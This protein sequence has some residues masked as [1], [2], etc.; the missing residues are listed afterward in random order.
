[1]ASA[2]LERSIESGSNGKTFTYSVWFKLSNLAANHTIIGL[3]SDNNNTKYIEACVKSNHRMDVQLR[4]GTSGDNG[5]YLR[6]RS[7]RLF[8]D[9]NAWTHFVLRVDSTQASASDRLRIYFDGVEETSWEDST[10][11]MP[12]DY[13]TDLNNSGADHRLGRGG[14]SSSFYMDGILSHFHLTDGQ[15]YGP[16]TF[17][18]TDSVTG[19]WKINTNPGISAS[20]YGTNGFWILKD[21]N[22]GT[23]HSGNSHNF[24]TSG[25][26][27]KT[28]DNPSNIFCTINP[29][30]GF[31]EGTG[32][33]H[34]NAPTYSN[35][36]TKY[37]KSA[38]TWSTQGCTLGASSGKYYWEAKMEN[39]GGDPRMYVGIV[40][41]QY[42][43]DERGH[44]TGQTENGVGYNG[45]NGKVKVSGGTDAN[46]GNSISAGDVVG[47]ALDLDNRKIYFSKNGTWQNSGDPT[48][49]STGTGAAATLTANRTY[50]PSFTI[51]N[52]G[53]L[54]NFG[55]GYFGTNAVSSAGTN[56]SGNGIFE[57]DVP[58]GYTAL[59]TKGLNT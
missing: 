59:S 6:R 35:G 27:T 14:G 11:T 39:N 3:S 24:T 7:N 43:N 10:G 53:C 26:I 13:V 19:E 20:N 12:Q 44:V 42:V 50:I 48:S 37:T 8:R 47:C 15:S 9:I 40:D 41:S 45:Y 22:T 51:H 58:T 56:A 38:A 36:N 30:I 2:Y 1:M 34:E 55:N 4:N 16:D 21:D 57:Y 28:E 54:A 52:S 23:D 31:R 17:G 29:S 33:Q 25:T 32:T 49:G 5:T 18:S 46:Y